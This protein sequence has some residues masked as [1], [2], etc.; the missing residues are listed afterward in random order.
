MPCLSPRFLITSSLAGRVMLRRGGML[1]PLSWRGLSSGFASGPVAARPLSR[2]GEAFSIRIRCV[3][4]P[5][6]RAP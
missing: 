4:F 3:S 6:C 1:I 2:S 5:F